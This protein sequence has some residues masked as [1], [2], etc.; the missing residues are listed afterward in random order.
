VNKIDRDR[1]LFIYEQSEFG[2]LTESAQL[3]LTALIAFLEDD[4][5]IV[6]PRHAAYMLATALHE[7]AD[8]YR[9][10]AEYGKGAGKKYGALIPETGQ[11]YY[12]RG[13]VQLTWLENYVAMGQALGVDLKGN[14]DLAMQPDI[15]YQIMS[16]GMRKGSFTGVS[17]HRFIDGEKCDFI[18][19]RKII[20]GTDCDEKIAGY[21]V[22]ILNA[23]EQSATA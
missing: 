6:D 21:A 16:R 13:Y 2:T 18:G 20:N 5:D 12:G 17:L 15:A 10:I 22:K 8:T 14:P 9:P 23:L 19:A 1:F 11:R 3:G 4:E 7:T